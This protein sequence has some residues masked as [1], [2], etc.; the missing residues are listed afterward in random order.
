MTNCFI[1]PPEM[2]EQ[3]AFSASSVGFGLANSVPPTGVE[4][5]LTAERA[6]GVGCV[7]VCL[8]SNRVVFEFSYY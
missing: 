1:F 4:A 2:W 7:C 8:L 6:S 3:S 5:Q